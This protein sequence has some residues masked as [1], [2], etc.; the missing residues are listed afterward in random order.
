MKIPRRTGVTTPVKD[1]LAF[2]DSLLPA[3]GQ[4]YNVALRGLPRDNF[5]ELPSPAFQG[6][7]FLGDVSMRIVPACDAA[8]DVIKNFGKHS[9][10]NAEPC[11]GCCRGSSQIVGRQV[12]N[13]YACA[14]VSERVV[15][16][17]HVYWIIASR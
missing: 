10:V 15:Y 7:A 1:A 12:I 2:G 5:I 4:F 8:V 17:E 14:V 13:A 11:H 6:R 16:G 9:T 3:L